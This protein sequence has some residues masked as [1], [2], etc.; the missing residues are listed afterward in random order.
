[1]FKITAGTNAITTL[2]TFSG[3]NGEQPSAGL[4]A[5]AAGNLYGVTNYGGD[6]TL[7]GGVGDGTVFMLN[8]NTDSFTTLASFN[9]ANGKQPHGS[10]V[11]GANGQ[12]FGTTS[13]GGLYGDG[14]VLSWTDDGDSHYARVLQW[15]QWKL[16][17][18]CSN[19]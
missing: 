15:R 13:Y 4:V 16:P 19:F 14:T 5:D 18:R 11:V 1:M 2:A 17:T 10:L 8:P 7:N 9:G 12:L 3:T 6:L